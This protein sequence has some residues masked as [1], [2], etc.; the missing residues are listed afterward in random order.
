M[1]HRNSLLSIARTLPYECLQTLWR[2]KLVRCTVSTLSACTCYIMRPWYTRGALGLP[3]TTSMKWDRRLVTEIHR[4]LWY[5]VSCHVGKRSTPIYSSLS[6]RLNDTTESVRSIMYILNV[7]FY[8]FYISQS[9]LKY[10]W[11]SLK[12]YCY[13]KGNTWWS[14][15]HI[16]PLYVLWKQVNFVKLHIFDTKHKINT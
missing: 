12:T 6:E 14:T 8:T 16:L 7:H 5:D 13:T 10:R 11:V 1:Q 3:I 4:V 15:L 9:Y 2:T